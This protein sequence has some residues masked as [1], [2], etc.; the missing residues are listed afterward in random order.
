MVILPEQKQKI[1]TLPMESARMEYLLDEIIV[2]S[3]NCKVSTK[4]MGLLKVM[5][6]SDDVMFNSVAQKLGM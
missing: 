2:P 5:K 1:E 6:K 3:L 4:F